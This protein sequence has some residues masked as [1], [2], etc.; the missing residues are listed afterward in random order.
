MTG[1]VTDGLWLR[2]DDMGTA[3]QGHR[4]R[5]GTTRWPMPN[6]ALCPRGGEA[7]PIDFMPTATSLLRKLGGLTGSSGRKERS[8]IHLERCISDAISI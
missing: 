2:E 3:G 6:L 1:M 4:T 5:S 8:R 7:S